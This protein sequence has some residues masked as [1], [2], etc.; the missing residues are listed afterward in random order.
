MWESLTDF[1]LPYSTCHIMS[2]WGNVLH[3]SRNRS[4]QEP[5]TDEYTQNGFWSQNDI[6]DRVL[7]QEQF[8]FVEEYDNMLEKKKSKI[9]STTR[10]F[11]GTMTLHYLYK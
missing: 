7:S 4:H 9:W 3:Q 11:A 8:Q 2:G 10:L 1:S 6:P 5:I